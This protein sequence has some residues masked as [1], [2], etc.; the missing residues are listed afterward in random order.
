MICDLIPSYHELPAA[1]Y[2]DAIK[3]LGDWFQDLTGEE[4]F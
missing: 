4:P 1:R 2:D 3:W